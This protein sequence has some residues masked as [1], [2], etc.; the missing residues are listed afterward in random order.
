MP[1]SGS[2]WL[3]NFLSSGDCLCY[4]EPM[5]YAPEAPGYRV[6]GGVDTGAALFL[7]QIL[8]VV[9]DLR[10]YALTRDDAPERCAALGLPWLGWPGLDV[11]TFRYE[12]MFHVKQ[13]QRIWWELNGHGF[14]E[15]RAEQLIEL[16]VQRDLDRL[17]ARI[18]ERL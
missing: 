1:R 14:D 16:N 11:V 7:P 3:A 5:V 10:I 17:R 9:P 8:A 6:V 2:A 13:L 15:R 12:E 4:H 18:Q